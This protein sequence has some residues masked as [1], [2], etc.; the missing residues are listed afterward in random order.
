MPISRFFC[1]FLILC[2]VHQ[3]VSSLY[4]FIASYFRTP[5]ASFFYLFLALTIFLMFGGFTLPKRKITIANWMHII[6]AN[7]NKLYYSTV[8]SASMPGWLNWG[9]WISPMTYAEISTAINEFQ[10]PRWQKVK[11][12]FFSSQIEKS[13]QLLSSI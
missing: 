7:I 12:I 2:L 10:A 6:Q 13:E 1:Q 11:C 9:F 5:T 3:S 8:V 4:R